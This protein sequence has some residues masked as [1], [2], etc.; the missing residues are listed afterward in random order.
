MEAGTLSFSVMVYTVCALLG[1]ALLMAR[2][3]LPVF[4]NAE[5]GGPTGRTVIYKM[6][7]TILS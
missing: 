1:L 4:G 7:T 2:R 3:F 5:L 6:G